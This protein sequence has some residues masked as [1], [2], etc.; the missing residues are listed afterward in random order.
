[1]TRSIA[2]CRKV[3]PMFHQNRFRM[4][5]FF[6]IEDLGDILK[7]GNPATLIAVVAL[8]AIWG[9]CKVSGK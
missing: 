1:M 7:N 2:F 3:R 9:I 8:G 5:D 4:N 6:G